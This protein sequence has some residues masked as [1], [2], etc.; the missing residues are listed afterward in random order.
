MN[1]E[2]NPAFSIRQLTIGQEKLP[3]F[4]VDNLMLNPDLLIKWADGGSG[5]NRR[6]TDFYPGVRKP[7]PTPYAGFIGDFFKV[8]LAPMI[9]STICHVSAHTSDLSVANLPPQQLLPIQRIPHFDSCDAKQWA[10]V[11]YLCDENQGG[12]GFFAHR[13]TGYEQITAHRKQ[14]YQRV[15]EDEAVTKG[16]PPAEYLQGS[17]GLFELIHQ[18]QA[19]FNRALFYPGNVL[20]SGLIR[21]WSSPSFAEARLTANSLLELSD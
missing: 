13:G 16:L 8:H 4:V 12:T 14:K 3:L 6:S 5:F 11:H 1:V 2:I 20:H 15:L 9:S 21:A 17:S 19:G 10:A 7:L 18:E